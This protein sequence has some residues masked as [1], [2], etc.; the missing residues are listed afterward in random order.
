MTQSDEPGPD[1][2]RSRLGEWMFKLFGP[3]Q[4]EGAIQGHSAEARASWKRRVAARKEERS[5][6]HDR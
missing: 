1:R 3:A 6:R 4:V 5:R 2:Q